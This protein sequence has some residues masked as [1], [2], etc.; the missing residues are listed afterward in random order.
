MIEERLVVA[1]REQTDVPS[2]AAVWWRNYNFDKS[3]NSYRS[4]TVHAS[5]EK[6]RAAIRRNESKLGS[7]SRYFATMDGILAKADYRYAIPMP[8]LI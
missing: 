5:E 1:E 2:S 6:A 8:E 4:F 3:G 7:G